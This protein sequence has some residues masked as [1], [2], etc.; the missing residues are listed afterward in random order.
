MSVKI[1]IITD[2]HKDKSDPLVE[3][4]FWEVPQGDDQYRQYSTADARYTAA[5]AV[6]ESE[7]VDI[8]INPGDLLTA[9]TS[10]GG[11]PEAMD[12]LMAIRDATTRTFADTLG[13]HERAL[14]AAAQ[15]SYTDFWAKIDGS[16]L[17]VVREN[18]WEADSDELA[19][20]FEINGIRFIILNANAVVQGGNTI[21]S[22]VSQQTW[23][24]DVALNTTL[25]C[26]VLV[27]TLLTEN[28]LY[29]YANEKN[30]ATVRG[31]LEATSGQVQ[32]VISG[33]FHRNTIAGYGSEA[34]MEIING[35]PYFNL[36]GSVLG[37]EDGDSS[38]TATTADSAF[39]TMTIV[40]EA[41]GT[42]KRANIELIAYE[43]GIGKVYTSYMVAG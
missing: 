21:G 31:L 43:K 5:L 2:L 19:Y 6:F 23:L 29:A 32:A 34:V 13:N 11:W 28:A 15:F 42:P 17:P 41:V 22:S 39:Y 27:H 24:T 16:N 4:S 7:S 26:V 37:A 8:V 38:D 18:V 20:T 25:P 33:H 36:R 14:D 40:P 10:T 12:D 9:G 35:I 3:Q 30:P 1:G